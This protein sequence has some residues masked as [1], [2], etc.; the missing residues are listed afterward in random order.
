MVSILESLG[1]SSH[2]RI[3]TT[4]GAQYGRIVIVHGA[5]ADVIWQG[6]DG[7]ERSGRCSLAKGLEVTPVAGDW[8]EILDER[9]VRVMQRRSELRRPHPY[10]REPQVMAANIDV[11]MIVVALNAELNR[12]VLESFSIM[13]HE[14]GARPVVVATKVDD[15][16]DVE[17]FRALVHELVPGVEMIVTSSLTGE[18]MGSLRSLLSLGVTAVM[19]GASGVGKTSLLNSL[20][21]TTEFTR[22][23]GRGGEGRHATTTRKLYRLASGGVLLDSPGIRLLNVVG[24]QRSLET[25][26]SDIDEL[27]LSCRFNN[28]GHDSDEGCAVQAAVAS[29]ELSAQRLT[30]WREMRDDAVSTERDALSQSRKRPR[31]ARRDAT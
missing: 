8:A 28:C 10:G 12:R 9:V 7:A 14:S 15:S 4:A 29:G 30:T 27:A 24:D 18:G 2:D 16:Q 3:P 1:L 13:A 17:Q 23:V 26:F 11:V 6:D 5:S 21:G 20:Q 25:V 19:L 31:D 22:T